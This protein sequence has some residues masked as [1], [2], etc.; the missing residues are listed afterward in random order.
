V[1]ARR[2]RSLLGLAAVAAVVAACALTGG[3]TANG[4][5]GNTSWVV[6]SIG[7]QDTIAEARPT[8][9][10]DPGG[11]VT[12]TNGCNSY[13]GRFATDGDKIT[14][15]QTSSTAMGC[16]ADRSAQEAAFNAAF[17]AATSWKEVGDGTLHLTGGAEI[18]A[19]PAGSV[20]PTPSAA[21]GPTTLVDTSWAATSIGGTAVGAVV[22]T[23]KFDPGT[24][25]GNSGCNT[26]NGTYSVDGKTIA[27]G[28]LISTKMACVGAGND[29]EAAFLAAL[30]G[31]STWSIAADGTLHL[32][33]VSPIVLAP[34]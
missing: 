12:G 28:P 22:P 4:G 26:Y 1:D 18:V 29:V 15:G 20:A 23:L 33:G 24:A 31:A 17:G 19:V 34:A 7:G 9:V 14:I 8:M 25:S 3:D 30:Q 5:L 16:E 32:E 10:F 27:F 11:T 13:S 2:L 6:L 21:G